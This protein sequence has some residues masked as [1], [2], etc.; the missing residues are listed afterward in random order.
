MDNRGRQDDQANLVETSPP[1][2][3]RAMEDEMRDMTE[4]MDTLMN[5]NTANMNGIDSTV[6]GK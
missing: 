4:K 3:Q 6:M 2:T 5:G 1:S